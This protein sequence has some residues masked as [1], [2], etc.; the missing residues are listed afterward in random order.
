[1]F[2]GIEIIKKIEGI[3]YGVPDG[4][5]PQLEPFELKFWGDRYYI[6]TNSDPNGAF[7]T[8]SLSKDK[9]LELK[10]II[11]DLIEDMRV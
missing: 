1:M 5:E 4:W 7:S 3:E 2:L 9:L 11:D 6:M 10:K 8:V